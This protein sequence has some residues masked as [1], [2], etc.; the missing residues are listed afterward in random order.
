MQRLPIFAGIALVT[1]SLL[2]ATA[3]ADKLH[4]TRGRVVE[5]TILEEKD[6]QVT[7][8]TRFGKSDLPGARF[9]GA[10]MLRTDLRGCNL[11][12]AELFEAKLSDVKLEL[13]NVKG[14]KL[15]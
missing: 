13:A 9:E 7:I 15:A 10:S 5:G 6:D 3:V 2:A 12:G 11:F 4:L 1:L 14:T 8:E